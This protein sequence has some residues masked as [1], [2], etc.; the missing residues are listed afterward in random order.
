[1]TIKIKYYEP[2]M[3]D[4]WKTTDPVWVEKR[5]EQWSQALE[6]MIKRRN[7]GPLGRRGLKALTEY[8]LTGEPF[9]I[10]IDDW[11]TGKKEQFHFHGAKFFFYTPY[12]NEDDLLLL[13]SKL[14]LNEKA[15]VLLVLLLCRESI[16][17]G[18]PESEDIFSEHEYELYYKTFFKEPV[19]EPFEKH[20]CLEYIIPSHFI[21]GMV[22]RISHYLRVLS[23][24]NQYHLLDQLD[25]LFFLLRQEV[26]A[27]PEFFKEQRKIAELPNLMPILLNWVPRYVSISNSDGQSKIAAR[28]KVKVNE[29][30]KDLH[31]PEEYRPYL[32]GKLNFQNSDFMFY[33][34]ACFVQGL[35]RDELL[36]K[37]IEALQQC[38]LT[39]TRVRISALDLA[40]QLTEEFERVL[41]NKGNAIPAYSVFFWTKPKDTIAVGT[42]I[43]LGHQLLFP[44]VSTIDTDEPTAIYL[45]RMDPNFPDDIPTWQLGRKEQQLRQVFYDLSG[46]SMQRGY[47]GDDVTEYQDEPT[48][49]SQLDD[50]F[51]LD[52]EDRENE[53]V[54]GG[55]G[56]PEIELDSLPQWDLSRVLSNV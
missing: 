11:D 9:P 43:I 15:E 46:H 27:N 16:F 19:R 30:F 49:K 17:P 39:V 40:G 26:S 51:I 52:Y 37:F 32:E 47:Q 22:S 50:F 2:P 18:V 24:P 5:R 44:V 12:D 36:L 42:D 31:Y 7:T 3:P 41:H 56:V 34:E 10:S 53:I 29:F 45:S 20:S 13:F 21:E 14:E 54:S 23:P 4:L 8:F 33:L 48:K 28:L 35:G 55:L 25:F 1:M 6:V 38:D